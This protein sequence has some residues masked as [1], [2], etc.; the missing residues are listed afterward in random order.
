MDTIEKKIII[1]SLVL[2]LVVMTISLILRRKDIC[3]GFLIGGAISVLNFEVLK[4][5]IKNLISAK[6]R[7]RYI[8]FFIGYLARYAIMALA[9]WIAINKG[10]GYFWSVA[11]GLFAVRIAILLTGLKT[12]A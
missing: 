7:F 10:F 3:V 8:I 12:N 4:L 2:I 11:V 6:S 1:A 9:L 5:H